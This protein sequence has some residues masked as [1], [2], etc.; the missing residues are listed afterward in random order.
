MTDDLQDN[1]FLNAKECTYKFL[2]DF[3]DWMH[4]NW[5]HSSSYEC[6]SGQDNESFNEYVDKYLSNRNSYLDKHK[7]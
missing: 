1:D 4:F 5:H 6:G 3:W 2:S 7:D